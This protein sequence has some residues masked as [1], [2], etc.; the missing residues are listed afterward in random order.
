MLAKAFVSS[1][2]A[3]LTQFVD[4]LLKHPL[5]IADLAEYVE[6]SNSYATFVSNYTRVLESLDDVGAQKLLPLIKR[7]EL[8]KWLMT[9]PQL[10]ERE[11]LVQAIY[12]TV[13]LPMCNKTKKSM[14]KMWSM[15][16]QAFA[17]IVNA[18]LNEMHAD[19][20]RMLLDSSTDERVDIRVWQAF[21]ELHIENVVD[22]NSLQQMCHAIT[23]FIWTMRNE[24]KGSGTVLFAR[25]GKYIPV[26]TEYLCRLVTSDNMC[27]NSAAMMSGA[28]QHTS[29]VCLSELAQPLV[30]TQITHRKVNGQSK[31]FYDVPWNKDF[32]KIGSQMVVVLVRTMIDLFNKN[33][34]TGS[35]VFALYQALTDNGPVQIHQMLHIELHRFPWESC[36]PTV[37]LMQAVFQAVPVFA[38]KSISQH[39]FLSDV[40]RR[41]DWKSG[42]EMAAM[43]G[44]EKMSEYHAWMLRLLLIYLN[45]RPIP[46]GPTLT[47]F[48]MQM[49]S[50]VEWRH[51]PAS[52]IH[53]ILNDDQIMLVPLARVE[54][55]AKWA[56]GL[57]P[58]NSQTLSE[59]KQSGDKSR[60]INVVTIEDKVMLLALMVGKACEIDVKECQ[61]SNQALSVG[62]KCASYIGFMSRLMGTKPPHGN[63]VYSQSVIETVY[64]S[65]AFLNTIF[66]DEAESSSSSS[67]QVPL[68][69]V[70]R[71]EENLEGMLSLIGRLDDL[72]EGTVG[73]D[74]VIGMLDDMIGLL[75]I[76]KSDDMTDR[77][78]GKLCDFLEEWNGMGQHVVDVSCRR[79]ANLGQMAKVVEM[80]LQFHLE[81][82]PGD[83]DAVTQRLQI[84]QLQ[85]EDFIE[86]CLKN[87]YGLVL[88]CYGKQMLES[89]PGD[90]T[91]R[92]NV[93]S[94]MGGWC[95]DFTP[96]ENANE[97]KA[98]VLWTIAVDEMMSYVS[99]VFDAAQ[100]ELLL[101]ISYHLLDNMGD[102]GV[103]QGLMQRLINNE[104]L[105]KQFRLFSKHFGAFLLHSIV[106]NKLVSGSAK[107]MT[108]AE[109][110]HE[111]LL[112]SLAQLAFDKSNEGFEDHLRQTQE[113]M[114][115]GVDARVFA[116]TVSEFWWEGARWNW[117]LAK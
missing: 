18:S 46:F 12:N 90:E 2:G 6:P 22:A 87:G 71:Y 100:A 108:K 10:H 21:A 27:K 106:M 37:D 30:S 17:V 81:N 62:M 7:F 40:L 88:C 69:S 20:V 105:S 70:E 77:V 104:T 115:S 78:I 50:G 28:G 111:K 74:I 60:V 36:A 53:D 56:K 29:W 93:L 51:I 85:E 99:N 15:Q 84:P 113:V 96:E 5:L 9:Q 107:K 112:K 102:A 54:G 98:I 58:D 43:F 82:H 79:I 75:N 97:Y 89:R 83:W 8:S 67:V 101:E 49:A 64:S 61:S 95:L 42:M 52:V 14:K 24:A 109:T 114:V 44:E 73:M 103:F 13:L 31:A 59:Y 117:M 19:I 4:G 68:F 91:H 66:D 26:V 25:W 45:S 57:I 86:L 41:L 116:S 63:K 47:F 65:T 3:H 92:R 94:K 35:G 33:Q 16:C 23:E 39:F 110:K 76:Q 11:R 55:D 32:E 48:F 72:M 1:S 34:V 80:G 38:T